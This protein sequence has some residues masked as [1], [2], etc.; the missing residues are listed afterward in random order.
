MKTI[1]GNFVLKARLHKL[2][3]QYWG[4]V[5][6]NYSHTWLKTITG[7]NHV[8]ELNQQQLMKAIKLIPRNRPPFPSTWEKLK[9]E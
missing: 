6:M 3:R 2:M 5:N 7:K 4:Y 8:S 1:R 9:D